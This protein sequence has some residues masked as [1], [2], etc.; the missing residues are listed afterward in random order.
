MES[1]YALLRQKRPSLE[2]RT[3]SW[4]RG[5]LLN[6][7]DVEWDE[8][9][10]HNF[11]YQIGDSHVCFTAH[12]DT[13][14]RAFEPN[15]VWFDTNKNIIY[16]SSGKGGTP[17]GADDAAG[18]YII[19]EMIKANVPGTYILFAD[20]ECGGVGSDS[21]NE[22]RLNHVDVMISLDRAGTDEVI[23]SQGIGQ[24]ASDEAGQVFA[25]LLSSAGLP[26]K[27][28]HL[29]PFPDSAN[30]AGIIPECFNLSVGYFDQHTKYEYL[31][32]NFLQK[33]T[34]V[35]IN[36]DFNAIPVNGVT[37]KDTVK[38]TSDMYDYVYQNPDKVAAY[39]EEI[40][41]DIYEIE[42]SEYNYNEFKYV[43]F[44]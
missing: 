41:V 6:H 38:N 19:L 33:L 12:Y 18:I 5:F 39:L 11:L 14:H 23:V 34:K 40:G 15:D 32:V 43:E 20:E 4:M 9:E 30:F 13:V 36:L 28:S 26:Y 35:M 25:S 8:D 16:T 7:S 42:A 22:A 24:C 1:L 3:Y 10:Q 29:G 31:D 21:F 37:R 27:V 44:Y 2:P 17:L